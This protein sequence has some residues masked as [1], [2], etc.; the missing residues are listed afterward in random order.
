MINLINNIVRSGKFK[1]TGRPVRI[2]QDD[3]CIYENVDLWEQR[4]VDMD[5]LAKSLMFEKR[6]NK[7]RNK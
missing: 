5:L 1:V 2:Y 3:Y 7:S 4:N 6:R